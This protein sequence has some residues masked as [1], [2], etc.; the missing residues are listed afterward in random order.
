[1]KI[2]MKKLSLVAC[3]VLAVMFVN[4]QINPISWSYTA[5]K[6][7]SKTYEVHVKATIE[8]GW[9]LFSQIQ[10]EDAIAEPT[11]INFTGNPLVSLD[12]KVK[13]VGKMEKFH[14]AK[15]ELSANQYASTVDFVQI[16]KL[17]TS[18]KTSLNGSVRFQTCNDSRCLPPKTVNFSVPLK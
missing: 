5:K 10:P 11:I 8:D 9:H 7:D 16:V 6:I 4:A 2:S 17:K 14:D 12:G 18:A 1:M 3:A 15:L 13:E